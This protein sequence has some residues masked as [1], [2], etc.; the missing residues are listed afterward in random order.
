MAKVALS[1]R[2]I[3]VIDPV[4]DAPV[5]PSRILWSSEDPVWAC[6]PGPEWLR[7][8]P[9][10]PTMPS[11]RPVC[12]RRDEGPQRLAHLFLSQVLRSKS[13]RT[14]PSYQDLSSSPQDEEPS[15]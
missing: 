1:A 15:Q 5:A 2:S 8:L 7:R 14:R 6:P 9:R 11:R 13:L 12:R 10:R 3:F 4:P